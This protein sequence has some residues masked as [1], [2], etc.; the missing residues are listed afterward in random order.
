M[1]TEYLAEKYFGKRPSET[2]R[3]RWEGNIE[4]DLIETE[5]EDRR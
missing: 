3:S 5:F 1:H 2:P 4:M